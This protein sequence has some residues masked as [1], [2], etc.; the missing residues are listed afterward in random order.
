MASYDQKDAKAYDAGAEERLR[1]LHQSDS[2]HVI[3]HQKVTVKE[4][5]SPAIPTRNTHNG[6]AVAATN[7]F[8][9]AAGDVTY[10][11]RGPLRELCQGHPP[12]RPTS[13]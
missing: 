9:Y 5:P 11:S 4:T 8:D 1:H 3:D 6:D 12:L 7:E 10:L 13:R 2:H